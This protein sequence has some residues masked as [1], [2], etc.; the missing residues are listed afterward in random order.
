MCDICR[1]FI[2]PDSCPSAVSPDRYCP[3]CGEASPLYLY[4]N[5]DGEVAGCD[6]CTN[7]V[8]AEDY[9]KELEE[10]DWDL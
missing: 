6:V 3:V 7:K 5:S 10:E 9:F 1:S 4:I 8:D 2:C